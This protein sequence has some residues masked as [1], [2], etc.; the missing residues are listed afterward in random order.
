MH[1]FAVKRCVWGIMAAALGLTMLAPAVAVVPKGYGLSPQGDD[2]SVAT[3]IPKGYGL[4]PEKGD[5]PAADPIPEGYHLGTEGNSAISTLR[6]EVCPEV[7]PIPQ[8]EESPAVVPPVTKFPVVDP[9]VVE[10]PK[11][12]PV[13]PPLV[14]A[15]EQQLRD[16]AVKQ[17]RG[18]GL[19]KAQ[20]EALTLR[21]VSSTTLLVLLE[22][23]ELTTD[24]LVYLAL[25]NGRSDR[26]DRYSSWAAAHPKDKAET[27]VLQVNMDRDRL[28]Y[29][30][31]QTISDP[32]SLTVLVNKNYILPDSYAPKLE[33]LGSGYGSGSLRPEAAQAFRAMADAA[34]EDGIALR[35]VS[36]YRSYATQRSTYNRYLNYNQQAVVDTF[37]ARPGHS[38]HQ[39]GLSLDINTANVQAHFENTPAYA[40][41]KEHC[42]EYGF[43]LRYLQG[44]DAITG[45]RF[46]PWHYRYV[47]VET[48][49][50]CMDQGVT[51]EE[52]LALQPN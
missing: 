47:G 43:I 15:T 34:R 23:G 48:A 44:K 51:Y 4:S 5:L 3:K 18:R 49:K 12:Q 22:Q 14:S 9:P 39:T 21:L 45:Y 40:W 50:A 29:E 7:P 19:S 25:P 42:A 6:P 8:P 1:N 17:L 35:S 37:S 26:L 38:E 16:R 27:V 46:E 11:E 31:I 33:A 36:A 28:F 30:D 20:T 52:Y 10:P 32:D 2:L 24:D 13:S 41:L